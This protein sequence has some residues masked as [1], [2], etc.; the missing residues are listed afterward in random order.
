MT[1]MRYFL[2]S[3]AHV[4]LDVWWCSSARKRTASARSLASSASTRSLRRAR[5]T[6]SRRSFALA[7]CSSLQRKL[8]PLQSQEVLEDANTMLQSP[9]LPTFSCSSLSRLPMSLLASLSSRM[10]AGV[11]CRS[12]TAASGGYRLC[13]GGCF[14]MRLADAA[15]VTGEVHLWVRAAQQLRELL[16]KRELL[17]LEH[18]SLEH[19]ALAHRGEFH[20]REDAHLALQLLEFAPTTL[21][22][23]LTSIQE[24]AEPRLLLCSY[25]PRAAS[26]K[27]AWFPLLSGALDAL[28][29]PLVLQPR[30]AVLQCT[31]FHS[32]VACVRLRALQH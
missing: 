12:S 28:H 29:S 13:D 30:A 11:C 26:G 9:P 4:L 6:C 8:A 16:G 22:L 2:P 19:F 1:W 32:Q 23:L 10:Q 24:L 17:S 21:A 25:R 5:S 18:L 27:R 3:L 20:V 7:S 31:A 15:A 14:V